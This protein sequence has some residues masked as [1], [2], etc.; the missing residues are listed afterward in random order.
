PRRGAPAFLVRPPRRRA[1][2][3]RDPRPGLGR[4]RPDRAPA[5]LLLHARDH[6]RGLRRARSAVPHQW[7]LPRPRSRVT[8]RHVTPTGADVGL[9]VR[10]S[11]RGRMRHATCNS[12]S[13]RAMIDEDDEQQ[14]AARL[15][16][17][18]RWFGGDGKHTRLFTALPDDIQEFLLAQTPFVECELPIIGSYWETD[19]WLI[20][21]TGR[22]AWS[23]AGGRISVQ[24][25]AI[26][27]VAI[28]AGASPV[29]FGKT[30]PQEMKITANGIRYSFGVE[31]GR[32]FVGFWNVVK[33]VAA[34]NRKARA[35][36]GAAG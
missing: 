6:R 33:T 32:A 10:E 1:R 19:R 8:S 12:R 15:A 24:L 28:G 27:R 7:H 31:P 25:D 17:Q 26:D 35:R 2:A 16:W 5:K 34:R 23:E 22:L 4:R 30:A 13:A 21:T 29:S 9:D 18:F 14:L 11:A 20:L 36:V 3:R